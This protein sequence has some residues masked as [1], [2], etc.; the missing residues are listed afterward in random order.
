VV[1][2]SARTVVSEGDIVDLVVRPCEDD[3][4]GGGH[5]GVEFTIDLL[6]ASGNVMS[7]SSPIHLMENRQG[8]PQVVASA[9]GGV[10]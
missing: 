9:E 8:E 4:A 6:T 5:V 10:K 1:E 7:S 3:P 2:P